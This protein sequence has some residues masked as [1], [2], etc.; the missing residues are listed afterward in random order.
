M[1]GRGFTVLATPCNTIV[2]G[3]DRAVDGFDSV[4]HGRRRP[5][6]ALMVS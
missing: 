4:V 1:M 5:K 2:K 3:F 6:Q